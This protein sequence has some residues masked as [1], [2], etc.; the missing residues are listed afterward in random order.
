MWIIVGGFVLVNL[1]ERI[2]IQHSRYVF[3]N[4]IY[5]ILVVM[6]KRILEIRVSSR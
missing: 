2:R 4:I 5:D 3:F 1:E 6:N